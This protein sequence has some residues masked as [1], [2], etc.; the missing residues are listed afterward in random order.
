ML[1]LLYLFQ[2]LACFI[3]RGKRSVTLKWY[4]GR[5]NTGNSAMKFWKNEEISNNQF[6]FSSHRI[7]NLHRKSKFQWNKNIAR[8]V[9]EL[10][11]ALCS[12]FVEIL[13][14]YA[15]LEFCVGHGTITNWHFHCILS[16]FSTIKFMIQDLNWLIRIN[17]CKIYLFT[18]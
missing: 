15:N 1:L 7:P 16:S 3:I 10:G 18:Y 14:F 11:I 13:I 6:I 8:S 4:N 12:Y 9:T 17:T 2:T 5:R